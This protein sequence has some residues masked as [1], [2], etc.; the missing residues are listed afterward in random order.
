MKS[1]REIVINKKIDKY[2]EQNEHYKEKNFKLKMYEENIESNKKKKL[3]KRNF[4]YF[5]LEFI[6]IK[7]K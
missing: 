6:F 7:Q 1:K 5:D 2:S 3:R 4:L